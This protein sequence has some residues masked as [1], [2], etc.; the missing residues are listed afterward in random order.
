MGEALVCVVVVGGRGFGYGTIGRYGKLLF[1]QSVRSICQII[2]EKAQK[3]LGESTYPIG[4]TISMQII[5]ILSSGVDGT[6][7]T[8]A[9]TWDIQRVPGW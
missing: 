8:N 9:P 3:N 4:R 5:T 7:Y 2:S 1:H 6:T